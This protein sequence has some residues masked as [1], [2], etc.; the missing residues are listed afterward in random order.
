MTRHLTREEFCVEQVADGGRSVG[1]HRCL[2]RGRVLRDGKLYCPTHDPVEGTVAKNRVKPD[3]EYEAKQKLGN[4][5]AAAAKARARK[6]G[7]GHPHYAQGYGS[8]LGGWTG[9]LT[10]TAE[11]TD[12]LLGWLEN[13]GWR[14]SAVKGEK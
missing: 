5:R 9:G 4:E 1:F 11:E 6:L 2:S 3:A 12:L 8:Q 13:A 10:L 14:A 7:L